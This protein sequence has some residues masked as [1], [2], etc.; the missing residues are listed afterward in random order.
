[1]SSVYR[2]SLIV[3]NDITKC[4]VK[5]HIGGDNIN[6]SCESSIGFVDDNIEVKTGDEDITIGFNS[7]FILEAL[8]A[9]DEDRVT[10]KLKGSKDPL[11]IA[12]LDGDDFIYLILPVKIW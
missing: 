2:A 10:L 7:S 11:I 6:V 12:P 3:I 5:I 4:P 9:C 8:R 1:M